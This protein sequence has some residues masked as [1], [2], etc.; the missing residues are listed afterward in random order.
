[1]FRAGYPD[2]R[3]PRSGPSL[4]PVSTATASK[5]EPARE[6]NIAGFGARLGAFVVDGILADLI[7]VVVLGGWKAGTE[8]NL[9]ILVAFLLIELLFVWL[10]G[11]TPG[12]RMVGIGVVRIDTGGRQ[13]FGWILA[14]TLLLAAIIPALLPDSTGRCMHDRAAGTATI[15]TR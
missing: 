11:Q 12:M 5:T 3:R 14:R 6:S 7:S 4:E 13:K 8:Q 10:A 1:M 9:V 2:G 15:R